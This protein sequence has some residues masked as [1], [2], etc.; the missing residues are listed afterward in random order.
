VKKLL[1]FV[2]LGIFC[3]EVFGAD[4]SM[5]DAS[6][7][8]DSMTFM[9]R[10]HERMRSF[11][12]S[13]D[14]ATAAEALRA[15]IRGDSAAETAMELFLDC[16]YRCFI[17]HCELSIVGMDAPNNQFFKEILVL[18][19]PHIDFALAPFQGN[20]PH[21]R[22]WARRIVNIIGDPLSVTPDYFQNRQ[23]DFDMFL[24]GAVENARQGRSWILSE[25]CL[26]ACD[27]LGELAN[28]FQWEEREQFNLADARHVTYDGRLTEDRLCSRAIQVWPN[29]FGED[30]R[31]DGDAEVNMAPRASRDIL[32]DFKYGII[33][34]YYFPRSIS[35][36]NG[37]IYKFDVD[38]DAPPPNEDRNSV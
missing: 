28:K 21:P 25:T 13:Y 30:L 6:S 27:R 19:S 36:T 31:R 14:P 7:G 8:E 11:E 17:E 20:P 33:P 2:V 18:L 9:R 15:K 35:Y 10:C 1:C 34:H 16:Q 29:F 26:K 23:F 3:S 22:E 38:E 12:H 32:S 5:S 4:S 37:F 24:Y